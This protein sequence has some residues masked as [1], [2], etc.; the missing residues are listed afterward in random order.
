VKS[1]VIVSL[2]VKTTPARAFQAFTEEIGIWWR[3]STLFPLGPAGCTGLRFEPGATGRLLAQNADGHAVEVGRVV[4][5]LP[6]ERLTF[7]WR[8]VSF[9]DDQTTTVDVHFERVADETRVT[10][11]HRGWDAIAPEHA[12]RHRFP[13]DVFQRRLADYWRSLLEALA[14]RAVVAS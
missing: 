1:A 12:T 3:P 13:L 14:S 5:W 7:T 4:E 2:R 10:V 8:P 9:A 6:G 11:Q